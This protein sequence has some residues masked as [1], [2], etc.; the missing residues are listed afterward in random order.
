MQRTNLGLMLTF[1]TLFVA[2]CSDTPRQSITAPPEAGHAREADRVVV[3]QDSLGAAFGEQESVGPVFGS[4]SNPLGTPGLA[5]YACD[6]FGTAWVNDWKA[7]LVGKTKYRAAAYLHFAGGTF[8]TYPGAH[9]ANGTN[10]NSDTFLG[11]CN[12][13]QSHDLIV[14][15]QRKISGSWQT[16]TTVQLPGYQKYTFRS[17]IPASYRMQTLSANPV[18]VDHYG[19][20]AG[21]DISP[22]L[23]LGGR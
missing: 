18:P 9:I 12:G 21:W 15:I 7:A 16:I 23:A 22:G 19:V 1:A 13:D 20:G 6:S 10:T 5:P 4:G 3:L 17:V 11:A 14:R 8:T 2:A